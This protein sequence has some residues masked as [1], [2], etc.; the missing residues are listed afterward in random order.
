MGTTSDENASREMNT[1]PVTSHHAHL[2]TTTPHSRSL[3]RDESPA[4][5][6][7]RILFLVVSTRASDSEFRF[8]V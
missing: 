1:Y 6:S 5:K 7:L 3:S 4:R 2:T 8:R